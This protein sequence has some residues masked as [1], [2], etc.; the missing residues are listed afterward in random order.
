MTISV[1]W[2][3][4]TRA[5]VPRM[6]VT[7]WGGF[8]DKLESMFQ[9]ERDTIDKPHSPSVS[10]AIYN[11]GGR[12]KNAE[13]QGFGGWFAIDIDDAG[14]TLQDAS[15]LCSAAGV[16]H[17][18]W[19]TTSHTDDA[20]RYRV[21]FPLDRNVAQGEMRMFWA[22]THAFFKGWGD[23][24]TKD[25]AR[26]MIAPARWRATAPIAAYSDVKRTSYFISSAMQRRSSE[27][28]LMQSIA[29]GF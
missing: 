11:A 17:V 6:Q 25:P 10:P 13:V 23:V 18:I 28:L 26:L 2:F 1:A 22:G 20:H 8:A 27:G 3:D 19:T 14:C 5:T 15:D 4:H 29:A 7:T 21:A 16:S 24:K 12:R 9:I